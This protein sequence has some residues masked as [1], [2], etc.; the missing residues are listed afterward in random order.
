MNP[1]IRPLAFAIS[2]L[3][4]VTIGL[5]Q[6]APTPAQVSAPPAGGAAAGSGSVIP[7]ERGSF[8]LNFVN[9]DIQSVIRAV[10]EQTGRNFILDPKVQGNVTIVS[11]QPVQRGDLYPIFLSALRANGFTIVDVNGFSKVVPEADGKL[12]ATPT[13]AEALR[14]KG[15]KLVTYVFQIQ[16]DSASALAQTLKPLIS[17]NNYIAAVASSNTIVITDYADNVKRIGRIIQSV[18]QA[19]SV[20][21]QILK[22]ANASAA[23]VAQILQRAI[24]ELQG[25]TTSMGNQVKGAV[26]V[27]GRSNS[28]IIRA[29]SNALQMRIARLAKNLDT[30]GASGSSTYVVQLQNAEAAKVADSLRGVLGQSASNASASV[31]P[32]AST[33]STPSIIT[34][35]ISGGP[36]SLTSSASSTNA[37][38]VTVSGNGATVQA[39][40]ETNSLI[41]TASEPMYRNLRAVIEQL[42]QRRSQ[43]YIE[44]LV[45]EVSGNT[46]AEIGVQW[47]GL[48]NLS[49]PSRSVIG[50]TNFNRGQTGNILGVS[51]N[52]TNV[53]SGFNIGVVNGLVK[54]PTGV[55]KDGNTTFTS[56]INLGMLANFLEG[57]GNT[58]ILSVPGTLTLDNEE[59][60]ITVGQNIPVVTGNYTVQQGSAS[61]PFQTIDR[62]DV[63]LKLRVKPQIS[64]GGTI[65]LV[66]EQEVS[67]VDRTA[68]NAATQ[69]PTI[70]KRAI[71]SNVLVEDGGVIAIGGLMEDTAGGTV[72]KVPFLGDL[73]FIGNAFRYQ[74]RSRVKRN[75]MVFIRPFVLRDRAGAQAFSA[76]KYDLIRDRGLANDP[77]LLEYLPDAKGGSLPARNETEKATQ[78]PKPVPAPNN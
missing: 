50:G 38:A 39:Y 9:A 22:L 37:A 17:A 41:I 19:P 35:T 29:D 63:G 4:I 64:E 32:A 65:K 31:S 57:Q 78:V 60:V 59:A 21:P 68:P 54:I 1:R 70:N 30:P 24:P 13:G 53:G 75:L 43:V 23:D 15:D 58:N 7:N 14:A 5:A 42:D 40:R 10:G 49:D 56:L 72:E 2:T 26:I 76:D 62:R 74:S 36:I 25:V 69:G 61:S 20:E 51:Q 66:V 73:P 8:T 52:I 16:N 45:A 47:Q 33:S 44:A 48:G 71:S 55:D 77:K 34:P 3:F 18:D 6:T 28:L 67:N 11:P 12:A 27:D 46:A